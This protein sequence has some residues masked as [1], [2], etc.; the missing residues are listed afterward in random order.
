MAQDIGEYLVAAGTLTADQLREAQVAARGGQALPEVLVRMGLVDEVAV[1][2]AQGK[3][4]NL[5]FVDLTKGKIAPE[6]LARIPSEFAVAQGL[7]PVLDKGGKLIVAIDDPLKRIVVDQLQFQ[8]GCEVACAM[9]APSALRRALEQHYGAAP[10]ESVARSMGAEPGSGDEGD[11]APM[12]Y[13]PWCMA[14][15]HGVDEAIED[16]FEQLLQALLK[17]AGA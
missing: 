4:H 2:R 9:A 11:D 12:D 17:A 8:L 15:L 1:A 6:V 10:E 7:L 13:G 14:Y 3:V 16:W 5:P